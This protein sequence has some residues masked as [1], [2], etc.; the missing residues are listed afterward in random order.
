MSSESAGAFLPIALAR[1]VSPCHSLV[2]L[3]RFKTFHYY[4]VCYG[5][6]GSEVFDVTVVIVLGMPKTMPT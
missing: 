5:D 3:Q 6:L 1:L 2:I 4:Y